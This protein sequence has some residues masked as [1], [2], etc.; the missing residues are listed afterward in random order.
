MFP[1][2]NAT[3]SMSAAKGGRGKYLSKS[4]Y[5]EAA[6][7]LYNGG[8]FIMQRHPAGQI[9]EVYFGS[10]QPDHA[11]YKKSTR[12]TEICSAPLRMVCGAVS[13]APP[14]SQELPSSESRTQSFQLHRYARETPSVRIMIDYFLAPQFSLTFSKRQACLLTRQIIFPP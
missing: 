14:P 2:G 4:L 9:C 11:G 12:R 5:Q 3:A 1:L 6:L 10:K 8:R 7:R 13:T